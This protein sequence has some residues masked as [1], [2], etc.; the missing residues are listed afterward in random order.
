M[1]LF[2]ELIVNNIFDERK[3]IFLVF[4]LKIISKDI[5]VNFFFFIFDKSKKFKTNILYLLLDNIIVRHLLFLA[6]V[7]DNEFD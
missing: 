4:F 6:N 7:E 3:E 2:K 5:I 1:N